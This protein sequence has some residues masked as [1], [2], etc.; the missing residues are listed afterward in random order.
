MK[1]MS[2]GRAIKAKCKDCAGDNKEVTLCHVFGCPLWQHRCGC[3]SVSGT[4]KR[5]M[6][7]SFKNHAKEHELLFIEFGIKNEDFFTGDFKF[8]DNFETPKKD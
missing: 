1:R 7:A 3:S 4:Y 8:K 6:N 5:R 2:P